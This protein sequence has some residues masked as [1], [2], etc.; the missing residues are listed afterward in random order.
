MSINDEIKR[1][2][3]LLESEMGNVKPLITE[4]GEGTGVETDNTPLGILKRAINTG[5]W[6]GK[7]YTYDPIESQPS[8]VNAGYLYALNK[9]DPSIKTG[10]PFIK[11]KTKD[12]IS[13]YMFGVPTTNPQY[14]GAYLAIT[15]DTAVAFD[16]TKPEQNY[17][18]AHGWMCDTFSQTL[19]AAS[20]QTQLTADQQAQIQTLVSD[21][22][23]QDT[24]YTFYTIKPEDNKN[25]VKT[26]D[27]SKIPIISGNSFNVSRY[28]APRAVKRV[29]TDKD[30][31]KRIYGKIFCLQEK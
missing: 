19:N 14:P 25:Y 13:V 7:G 29:A 16:K 2:L 18:Q 20:Q 3:S 24:G 10:D 8:Y 9:V 12:G 1:M 22:G 17:L 4:E 11:V 6:S 23:T 31:N 15:R 5:C 21:L 30:F 28:R 27:G 26:A